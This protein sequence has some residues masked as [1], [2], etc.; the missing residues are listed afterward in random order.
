MPNDPKEA[1]VSAFYQIVHTRLKDDARDEMLASRP[2]FL[3]AMRSHLPGLVD[4]TLI[5]L[6]DGTWLDIVRWD[7]PEAA[8]AG[9]QAH[10]AVPGASAMGELI[11][12]VIAIFQGPDMDHH[13]TRTAR[14]SHD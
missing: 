11:A 9:A 3:A 6:E 5:E 10:T 12:E 4:A 13:E 2:G 14:L 7:S 1:Q 8:L